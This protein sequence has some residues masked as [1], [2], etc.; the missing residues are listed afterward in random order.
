MKKIGAGLLMGLVA[1]TSCAQKE[2]E[3]KGDKSLLWK[4]TGNGLSKPSY[5][6]GTI[7]MLCKEDA[8][9]S[10][11]MVKALKNADAVYLELD[12]DNLFDMMSVMNKMNMRNDTTLADL[13]TEEEYQKVKKI[14]EEKSSLLPFSMIEKYKPL[15]ASA[16]LMESTMVCEEQVAMEQL[17]MEEAKKHGKSIE[18]METAAFQMSIFD[19]IPYKIQVEELAKMVSVDN[20]EAE[21]EK[22]LKDMMDAYREQDLTKLGDMISKSEAG[23]M[24]YEDIL[25]NNRNHNWTEKM[26]KLMPEKSLVVAVGAG[27]LPGDKG[28]INLLRKAGFTVEPVVNKV[29]KTKSI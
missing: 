26:K 24:Q 17:I 2:E 1:L 19:S 20:K 22:E 7:H 14:F 25:L 10:E 9:L 21:G 23:M 6:F 5:L 15:L 29:R 28:V 3:M 13:L 11:N 8:F 12:M 27:H 4:V 18:G 16:M